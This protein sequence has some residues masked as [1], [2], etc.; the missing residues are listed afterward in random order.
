MTS[1]HIFFFMTAA[2]THCIAVLDSLT[3]RTDTVDKLAQLCF[4][5]HPNLQHVDVFIYGDISASTHTPTNTTELFEITEH[6]SDKITVHRNRISFGDLDIPRK[7]TIVADI[8]LHCTSEQNLCIASCDD[9]LVQYITTY[10]SLINTSFS[11]FSIV[12]SRTYSRFVLNGAHYSTWFDAC[13]GIYQTTSSHDWKER[14]LCSARDLHQRGIQCNSEFLKEYVGVNDRQTWNILMVDMQHSLLCLTYL[15]PPKD[16]L[17]PRQKFD[18]YHLLVK[19]KSHTC[20]NLQ[21]MVKFIDDQCK[22]SEGDV[23]RFMRIAF[24]YGWVKRQNKHSLIISESLSNEFPYEKLKFTNKSTSIC[25]SEPPTT[26]PTKVTIFHAKSALQYYMQSKHKERPV[27]S[28]ERRGSDHE[29]IFT[30]TTQY[31][32]VD[33]GRA[34]IASGEGKTKKESE[35]HAASK[36]CQTITNQGAFKFPV[37]YCQ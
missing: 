7:A 1:R 16:C 30:T 3:C 12:H 32:L 21:H 35:K 11:R 5:Q 29:P 28:T 18:L 15:P 19:N 22:V 25:V 8:M 20:E 4:I 23:I 10:L 34:Y 13:R 31:W 2:T 33:D 36:A 14:L 26:R 6:R 17:S 37:K 24:Y 27:Y 9:D